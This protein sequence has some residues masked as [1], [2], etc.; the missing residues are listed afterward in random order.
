MP[1][2]S[3]RSLEGV[4]DSELL[5][6]AFEKGVEGLFGFAR[7]RLQRPDREVEGVDRLRRS[8]SEH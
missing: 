7:G 6:E 1:A 5:G 8:T 4:G 2:Q 3:G